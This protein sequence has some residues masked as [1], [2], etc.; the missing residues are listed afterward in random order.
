[1]KY[2]LVRVTMMTATVRTL[3]TSLGRIFSEISERRVMRVFVRLTF[4]LDRVT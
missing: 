1:M 4:T 2:L 3:V